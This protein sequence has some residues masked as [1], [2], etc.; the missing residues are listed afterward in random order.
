VHGRGKSNSYLQGYAV[1]VP[2]G[3]PPWESAPCAWTCHSVSGLS[4]ASDFC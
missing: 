4:E 1:S 2:I 3:K